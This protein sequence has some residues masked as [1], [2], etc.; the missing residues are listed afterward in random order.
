MALSTQVQKSQVGPQEWGLKMCG[1]V[2]D[3]VT[4]LSGFNSWPK[5]FVGGPAKNKAHEIPNSAPDFQEELQ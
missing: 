1:L 2:L 3:T 5:A 4:V